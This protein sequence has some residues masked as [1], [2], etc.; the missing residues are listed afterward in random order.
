MAILQTTSKLLLYNSF[1]LK[2]P[3]K[4]VRLPHTHTFEKLWEKSNRNFHLH[5]AWLQSMPFERDFY[6]DSLYVIYLPKN[7]WGEW[8]IVWI[9][10]LL[11]KIISHKHLFSPRPLY[12]SG[13]W[14]YSCKIYLSSGYYEATESSISISVAMAFYLYEVL[15]SYL[16][17]LLIA[18]FFILLSLTLEMLYI[19]AELESRYC[20][21]RRWNMARCFSI[22]C[23]TKVFLKK[24][25]F[26]QWK[27]NETIIEKK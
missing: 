20:L 10:N 12:L 14:R 16:L 3:L 23:W 7:L 21:S 25:R 24:V 22:S 13:I 26:R 15:I 1:F 4:K 27:N 5:S 18:L 2:T 8:Q 11:R 6:K 9:F 19:E 17:N